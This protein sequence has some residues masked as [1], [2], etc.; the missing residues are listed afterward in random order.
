MPQI[1][2][3]RLLVFPCIPVK[4]QT[5][6]H[7]N[8]VSSAPERMNKRRLGS[9]DKLAKF[10]A[11]LIET[12]FGG[13]KCDEGVTGRDSGFLSTQG[14]PLLPETFPTTFSQRLFTH[15]TTIASAPERCCAVISE[16]H[17]PIFSSPP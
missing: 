17:T 7:Y 10:T 3:R 2:L 4:C 12:I 14:L 5:L 1:V 15:L 6:K 13:Y 9:C 11:R 16:L 8:S